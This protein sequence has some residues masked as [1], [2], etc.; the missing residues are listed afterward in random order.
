MKKIYT[1]SIKIDNPDKKFGIF[2]P[3]K[4]TLRDIKAYI[5]IAPNE[6]LMLTTR[7]NSTPDSVTVGEFTEPIKN[8]TFNNF[9]SLKSLGSNISL[10][11]DG[12]VIGTDN[13]KIFD[14]KQEDIDN[15]NK[16]LY[17]N[18]IQSKI[19]NLTIDMNFYEDKVRTWLE[20]TPSRPV[21]PSQWYNSNE[22]IEGLDSGDY[23]IIGKEVDDYVSSPKNVTLNDGETLE[24][25]LT[26]ELKVTEDPPGEPIEDPSKPSPRD[27]EDL[28]GRNF[29]WS[30]DAT[31]TSGSFASSP[32]PFGPGLQ[33]KASWAGLSLDVSYSRGVL[34]ISYKGIVISM[35]RNGNSF[36]PIK[37][38]YKGE[39]ITDYKI[40]S[41][42]LT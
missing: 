20:G 12:D 4:D 18:T 31:T 29:I 11:Y 26:Y 33:F 1:V 27:G 38:T 32:S 10:R 28:L 8:P 35:K 9:P 42:N 24:E 5:S 23:T 6:N 36:S 39:I 37:V 2:V 3:P 25:I 40:G 34:R 13:H 16:T 30:V 14:Y 41:L 22:L 19:E 21:R 15:G 7:Y 17:F